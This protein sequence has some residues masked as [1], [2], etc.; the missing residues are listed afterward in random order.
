MIVADLPL[1]ICNV[2]AQ[3]LLGL[4]VIAP[5]EN[6]YIAASQWLCLLRCSVSSSLL[7]ARPFRVVQLEQ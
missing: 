3:S 6:C 2:R 4:I 5:N 7:A 1:Q